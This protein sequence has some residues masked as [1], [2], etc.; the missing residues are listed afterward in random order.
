MVIQLA[1]A[2]SPPLYRQS[3][4]DD[5]QL[6]NQEAMKYDFHS[7][8]TFSDGTLTPTQLLQ[9]AADKRVDVLALTDHDNTDGLAE[10]RMVAKENGVQLVNGVEVSASW[11]KRLLHIVG[12]GIDP[13]N[14]DLASGLAQ[15]QCARLER[16][17]RMG[18]YLERHGVEGAYEG[19]QEYCQEGLL[20]RTHF[21][22]FLIDRGY[23]KDM[24]QVFKR[25]LVNG[26]PGYVSTEWAALED[27]VSW[28]KGAGGV[29]V[30]AHP[31]RYKLTLTKMKEMLADFVDCGGEGIEVI[32]SG[33]NDDDIRLTAALATDYGLLASVGSDFHDPENGRRELGHVAALPEQ[34]KPIWQHNA[35]ALQGAH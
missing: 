24:K 3:R 33:H 23:A 6:Q 22:R 11:R 9:R 18:K 30:I 12:L 32:G 8:S 34:C 10:A 7:H 13:E 27:A 21:A 1:R 35:L 14:A 20:S 4:S 19:A 26:K 15:V 5:C 29:A 28:I 31:A 2:E 17:Q 16:A 25:Y